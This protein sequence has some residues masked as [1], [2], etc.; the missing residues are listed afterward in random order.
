MLFYNS[1]LA[2]TTEVFEVFTSENKMS[3]SAHLDV[4]EILGEASLHGM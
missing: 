2:I 4:I 1:L 3:L